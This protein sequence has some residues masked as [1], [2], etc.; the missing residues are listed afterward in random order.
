MTFEKAF[1]AIKKKFVNA[2]ASKTDNFAVQITFAD[3]DCGG[4]FYAEVKDGVLHVE[5]YDYRDNDAALT[6]TKGALLGFL[7]KRMSLEKA[8]SEVGAVYGDV[9]KIENLRKLVSVEKRP[10]NSKKAAAE[11]KNADSE[12]ASKKTQ[13]KRATRKNTKK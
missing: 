12:K 3:E 7:G 1:E 4:T 10:Y 13:T 5:P 11:T 8:I 9:D 2:D 6:I